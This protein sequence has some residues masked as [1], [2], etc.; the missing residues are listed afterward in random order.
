MGDYWDDTDQYVRNV[1]TDRQITDPEKLRRA[2]AAE[3]ILARIQPGGADGTKP[4][5]GIGV[6]LDKDWLEHHT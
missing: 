2:V 5:L 1:L 6:N 4:I 3:P